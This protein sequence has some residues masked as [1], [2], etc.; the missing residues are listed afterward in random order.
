MHLQR[1]DGDRHRTRAALQAAEVHLTQKRSGLAQPFLAQVADPGAIGQIVS[2]HDQ[3]RWLV[4]LR[5]FA[6]ESAQQ[7][8]GISRGTAPT[9]C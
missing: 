2:T 5:Q 1:T 6:G 4:G 9:S 7:R 8:P 3:L